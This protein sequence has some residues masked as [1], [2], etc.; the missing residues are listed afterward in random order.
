MLYW[1]KFMN[2]KINTIIVIFLKS[3][4]IIHIQHWNIS[5]LR[6]FFDLMVQEIHF[7]WAFFESL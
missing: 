1:E 4:T 3:N 7:F 5:A 6:W 2:V